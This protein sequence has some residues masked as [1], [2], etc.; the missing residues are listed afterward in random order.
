MNYNVEFDVAEVLEYDRTYNYIGPNQTDSNVSE[1]FALK[2]RSCSKYF[3]QKIILAK[4]S[5]INIKQIPMVGEFVLI[6][7]TFNQESTGV[8]RREAWYYITSIDVQSSMNE[9][10]LPGISDS[11]DQA[12]IDKIKPGKNFDRKSI[13]PLQPYEGD[14][15]IEGRWGNSIRFSSTIDLNGPQDHYNVPVPW[16]GSNTQGSPIIIL[17]NGR[18]NLA[19][20]KFVAENIQNDASSLYLTSTQKLTTFKLNNTLRIGE[21]ESSFAK[22][23]FIGVAD[24]I[25]LKAKTDVVAL[26][27]QK[28]IEI[29]SPKIKI[30]IG[31]YEPLLQSTATV[32]LLRKI[33]E[34]IQTGFVDSSG[35]ISTPI[36]QSLAGIDLS[37][38]KSTTIEIDKWRQ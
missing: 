38:L 20:K 3:N 19:N 24:R 14:L 13:S 9:N 23:Q 21:S 1:L 31:P 30:G 29:L 25:L 17:S 16:K 6:Y 32:N 26:D 5:N 36:N 37:K 8:K 28:G 7:K 27:S 33:I 10:M 22:S 11:L 15:V 4:P 18:D 2:V 34:V 35:A 12:A